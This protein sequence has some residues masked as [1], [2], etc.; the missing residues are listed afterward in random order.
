MDGAPSVGKLEL[1]GEGTQG[2]LLVVRG[3]SLLHDCAA[4]STS[5]DVKNS[6]SVV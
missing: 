1:V 4:P 6:I 2:S 3:A 5:I